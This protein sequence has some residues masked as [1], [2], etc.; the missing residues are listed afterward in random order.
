M[1]FTNNI[2]YLILLF[3]VG[4]NRDCNDNARNL[5]LPA[6]SVS[7][8]IFLAIILLALRNNCGDGFDGFLGRRRLEGRRERFDDYPDARIARFDGCHD[9]CRDRCHDGCDEILL[10]HNHCHSHGYYPDR[11]RNHAVPEPFFE[12][13]NRCVRAQDFI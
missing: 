11:C 8:Y 9:G 1:D 13:R 2:L 4:G 10:R 7:P 5:G 12:R 3:A 6:S